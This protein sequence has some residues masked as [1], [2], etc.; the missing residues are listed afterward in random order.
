[1]FDFLRKRTPPLKDFGFLGTDMHA[2]WLPGLDDGAKTVEDSLH[3]IRQLVDMGYRKLI[4][5]PHVMADF[6]PNTPSTIMGALEEVRAAVAAAG[7]D[8][9]LDAAAEYLLDE[10]FRQKLHSEELLTLPG[11]H[12]LVEFSF[13]SAP[14]NRD[15]LFFELLTKGYRPILAHPERYAY[16]HSR[17][18]EYRSIAQRGIKLQVN[19]LSLTGYYGKREKK[20]AERLIDEGLVDIL[21]T[22]AHHGRHLRELEKLFSSTKLGRPIGSRSWQNC[23]LFNGV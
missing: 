15:A 21:G 12:V 18:E 9:Q 17:F 8:V 13:V 20:T 2:H 5:T 22:D 16:Y 11:K 23:T 4:A 19:L 1:M 14:K 3:L 10:G 7:I 6:Y